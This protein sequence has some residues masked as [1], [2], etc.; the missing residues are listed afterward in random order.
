MK[1]KKWIHC[2]SGVTSLLFVVALSEYDLV[3]FEDGKTN[4]MAEALS[5]FEDVANNQHLK[6][7]SCYVIFK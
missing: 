2:F 5:V 7:N 1:E 3:L 6:K 4:R